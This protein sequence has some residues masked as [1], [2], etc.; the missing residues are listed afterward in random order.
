MESR[1]VFQPKAQKTIRL[2]WASDD[3]VVVVGGRSTHQASKE[4]S[5]AQD[6]AV[7]LLHPRLRGGE[8]PCHRVV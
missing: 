3:V 1:V 8:S 5:A 7:R 4:Q 6:A 2:K